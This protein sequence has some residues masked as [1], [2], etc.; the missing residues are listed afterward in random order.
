M[1]CPCDTRITALPE[2][3]KDNISILLLVIGIVIVLW[4][5]LSRLQFVVFIPVSLGGMI[6]FTLGVIVVL[7]SYSNTSSS[8]RD[9]PPRQNTHPPPG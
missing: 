5:I 1:L 2:R 9:N 7:I 3:M 8:A 4:F 6:L